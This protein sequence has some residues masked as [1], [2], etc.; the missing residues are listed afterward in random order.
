ME[1]VTHVTSGLGLRKFQADGFLLTRVYLD[2]ETATEVSKVASNISLDCT[3][4]LERGEWMFVS[5]V[6]DSVSK[7]ATGFMARIRILL[8]RWPCSLY[9]LQQRLGR[10]LSGPC[11]RERAQMAATDALCCFFSPARIAMYCRQWF[12]CTVL[13]SLTMPQS[14]LKSWL[15]SEK[16]FIDPFM[17]M[18]RI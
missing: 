6:V 16:I 2:T 15:K 8:V 5:S 9:N 7:R 17:E 13:L 10:P 11:Q 4:G 12:E 14:T 3:M 1:N 18:W